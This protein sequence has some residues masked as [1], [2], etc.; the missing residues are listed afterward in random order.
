M[1]ARKKTTAQLYA[2]RLL[3]ERPAPDDHRPSW[4]RHAERLRQAAGLTND[5]NDTT[6]QEEDK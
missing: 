3:G 6:Q 4:E 5:T 1:T 2:D